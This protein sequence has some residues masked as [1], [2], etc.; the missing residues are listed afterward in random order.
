MYTDKNFRSSYK[1]I[2]YNSKFVLE[3]NDSSCLLVY[4]RNWVR[5]FGVLRSYVFVTM[6]G[7]YFLDVCV[8]SLMIFLY[9][10][11]ARLSRRYSRD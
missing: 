10:R 3:I 2:V 6:S 4:E 8:S 5:V 7:I 11:M 1:N 9:S